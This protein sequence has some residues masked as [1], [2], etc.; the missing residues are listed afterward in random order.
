MNDYS[1][2]AGVYDRINS[3]VDYGRWAD[4][5]ESLFE[6]YLGGRPELVLDLA[7]GT[8]SMTLELAKRGYDMIGVDLSEEMLAEATDRMYIMIDDGELPLEG[9]R[10]LFLCQDIREFEL[11]GTVGAVV[12]CLDSLNYLTGEG[13]LEKTF[14]TV[15]NYLDPSGLFIFDMNTPYKFEN[16][17]GDN[18]YVYELD[19]DSEDEKLC[20]WQNYYDRESRICDFILTLFERES[21]GRYR[22]SDEEQTERCYT[23]EEISEALA[24]SG[25][26]LI[27][28]SAG[29]DGVGLK[30]GLAKD[31]R[32][33]LNDTERWHFVARR[34]EKQ[35]SLSVGK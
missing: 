10:P 19:V 8:G 2:I 11:Y 17:Y 6:K 20:V 16:I 26:E 1:V 13:D 12:C 18:S 14:S 15:H 9:R 34:I 22:R 21:D 28:V 5:V 3:G 35:T 30:N 31:A 4:Y 24:E 25:F 7:S 27:G 33:L 29:Y 32:E 23:F